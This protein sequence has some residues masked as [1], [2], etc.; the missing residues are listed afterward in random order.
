MNDSGKTTRFIAK[1]LTM[2]ASLVI[3]I[4][5]AL[6]L[7]DICAGI[8]KDSPDIHFRIQS[9]YTRWTVANKYYYAGMG[10]GVFLFMLIGCFYADGHSNNNVRRPNKMKYILIFTLIEVLVV[11]VGILIFNITNNLS[12]DM[13]IV[14]H[15]MVA[16]VL[17]VLAFLL[18]CVLFIF[19]SKK[20]LGW[21]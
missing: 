15:L 2:L 6:F 10:A 14:P 3:L 1:L 20:V 7:A 21:M 4:L 12:T 19:P 8:V 13:I 11:A 17:P 9:M 18:H 16:W 5:A